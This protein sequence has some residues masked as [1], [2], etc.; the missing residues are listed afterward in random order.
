MGIFKTFFRCFRVL[1]KQNQK[2]FSHTEKQS[3]ASG[4]VLGWGDNT[5]GSFDMKVSDLLLHDG[6]PSAWHA[7]C[8]PCISLYL[9]LSCITSVS[10]SFLFP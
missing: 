7:P 2:N 3:H 1:G 10:S 6:S 8:H 5:L 4:R 9:L